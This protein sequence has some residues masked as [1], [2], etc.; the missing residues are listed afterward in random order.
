MTKVGSE[1]RQVV[2]MEPLE[3]YIEEAARWFKANRLVLF[4]VVEE[5]DVFLKGVVV[6]VPIVAEDGTISGKAPPGQV[7]PG[8]HD[9][10]IT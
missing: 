8:E 4:K 7:P 9:A 5:N 3:D 10:A 6:S 2:L 1:L